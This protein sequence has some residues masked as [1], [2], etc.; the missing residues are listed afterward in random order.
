MK[1]L[2][3]NKNTK[4][5]SVQDTTDPQPGP[6]EIL[7]RVRAVALNHVDY[8]NVIKPLAAQEKRVVGSDFAGEVV[9]VGKDL[10]HID[11]PRVKKGARVA[12]FL[13]GGAL[14][15]NLRC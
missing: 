4:A 12:G 11:D 5:V 14:S 10:E 15:K 9:Q 1:A 8:M 13:Q 6:K 2:L 7:V 3:L